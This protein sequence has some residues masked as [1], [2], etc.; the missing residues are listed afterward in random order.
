MLQPILEVTARLEAD[1]ALG[2]TQGGQD[3]GNY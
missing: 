1:L 3:I 2:C